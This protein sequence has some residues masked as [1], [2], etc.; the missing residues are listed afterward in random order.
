MNRHVRH[1]MFAIVDRSN[2]SIASCVTELTQ[3]VHRIPY[4][5]PLWPQPVAVL[6]TMGRLL[7]VPGSAPVPWK[8]DKGTVLVIDAG[9]KQETVE[10][11]TTRAWRCL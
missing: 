2:L 5:L 9:D 3:R 11:K 7:S 10:V 6:Q 1:R 4:P 8:I